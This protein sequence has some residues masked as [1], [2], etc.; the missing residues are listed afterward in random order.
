MLS[1][2]KTKVLGAEILILN[3]D[4]FNFGPIAH[5]NLKID[6]LL[7]LEIR[8]RTTKIGIA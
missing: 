4:I 1:K 7:T 3:I 8:N 6:E 2:V 5:I